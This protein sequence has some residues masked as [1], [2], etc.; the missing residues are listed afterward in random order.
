MGGNVWEWVN[1]WFDENNYANS[2]D[3]NP[4][5]L[6]SGDYKVIVGGSWFNDDYYARSSKRDGN[7]PTDAVVNIG[8]RCSRSP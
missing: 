7:N 6:N 3:S 5:G 2:P 4:L 8:F 1:D